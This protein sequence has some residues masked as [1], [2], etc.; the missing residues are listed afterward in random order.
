MDLRLLQTFIR[1]AELGSFGR[2]AETL[3]QTQPTVSRQIAALEQEVGNRLFVRRRHG[4]SLTPAGAVFRD[5]AMQALRSLDQAK[6]EITARAQEPTGTVSLGLPPSLLTA[7]SG[8]VVDRFVR[9]YPKVLL[10]VYEAISQGLEEL[11]LTQQVDLAVLIS[12]RRLLR[13]VK[14]SPLGIEPLMLAGPATSRLDP[15]RPVGIETLSGL[16]LLFYRP[17]NHLRL[18]IETALRR[19]GLVFHV[20]VE[21]ETLPLMLEL[22]ERGVGYTV[23]PPS[24]IV[25]RDARIKATPIRGLSVTWTLGLNRDRANWPAVCVLEAMIREQADAL[26]ASGAWKAIRSL[27]A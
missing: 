18:L 25:G 3:N 14:L 10:H 21:L 24:T 26:I 13:N 17:P 20:K 16:P 7:L 6:A 11:M 19:R 2:A 4:V 1:I 22:I 23:L 27:D 15:T 12:D 9:R 5:H 8:P